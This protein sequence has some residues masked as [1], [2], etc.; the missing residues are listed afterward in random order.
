[1]SYRVERFEM[2]LGGS[3]I[4]RDLATDLN[5]FFAF[6]N[7][8]S[9][10]GLT[11]NWK[12]GRSRGDTLYVNLW[13]RIGGARQWAVRFQ[14]PTRAQ[15][16]SDLQ[17][18]FTTND[19]FAP[20][21]TLD[22]VSPADDSAQGDLLVIYQSRRDYIRGCRPGVY[23]GYG[24]AGGNVAV[25]DFGTFVKLDDPIAPP[26]TAMNL[27]NVVWQEG[28]PGI[29]FVN[30]DGCPDGAGCKIGGI[31]QCCGPTAGT[32]GKSLT[33]YEDC[34]CI[35]SNLSTT[36]GVTTTVPATTVAPPY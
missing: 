35:P 1:M 14:A 20:I 6:N 29:L 21:E 31:P 3:R 9:V 15:V 22:L 16:Q 28:R 11:S 33:Y 19:G 17:S 25:G 36:P 7:F 10:V 18:F 32:A 23:P 27:G 24:P 34:G 5:E 12:A 26:V 30:V 8:I 13:Y 2:V 4:R